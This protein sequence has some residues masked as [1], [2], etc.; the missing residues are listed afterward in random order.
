MRI[1]NDFVKLIFAHNAEI[2]RQ[3]TMNAFVINDYGCNVG[4]D[5]E[6]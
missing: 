2:I 6:K 1:F 4:H 5:I 3:T